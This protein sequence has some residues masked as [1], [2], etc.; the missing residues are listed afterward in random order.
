[1]VRSS[2]VADGVS[3][4]D[5]F[6]IAGLTSTMGSDS[7]ARL[8]TAVSAYRTTVQEKGGQGPRGMFQGVKGKRPEGERARRGWVNG[9]G[10]RTDA[11][12]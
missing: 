5:W 6:E 9:M 2:S 8:A 7:Y 12:D 3:L 11:C 10:S 4:T 1:M